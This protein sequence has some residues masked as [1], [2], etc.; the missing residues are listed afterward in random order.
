MA[1]GAVNWES[2]L[3]RV[4]IVLIAYTLTL[5]VCIMTVYSLIHDPGGENTKV[6]I[7]AVAVT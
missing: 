5:T 4:A 1:R 6:L 3:E 7:Q 2:L